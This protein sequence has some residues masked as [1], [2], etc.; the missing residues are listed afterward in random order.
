MERRNCYSTQASTAISLLRAGRFLPNEPGL[1]RVDR[2]PAPQAADSHG[3]G[4]SRDVSVVSCQHAGIEV[5]EEFVNFVQ[6]IVVIAHR[7]TAKCTGAR[8]EEPPRSRRSS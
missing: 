7:H 5:L 2:L 3:P 1:W 8:V 6:L 4:T